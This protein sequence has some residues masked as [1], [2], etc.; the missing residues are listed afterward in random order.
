MH[1]VAAEADTLV[2]L[3]VHAALASSLATGPHARGP[4]RPEQLVSVRQRQ[5][6]RLAAH[7]FRAIDTALLV[8]TALLALGRTHAGPLLD[9][10]LGDVLAVAAGTAAL[11]WLLRTM[12]L[13]RFGR[14]D[15]PVG[16]VGRIAAATGLAGALTAL[17]SWLVPAPETTTTTAVTAVAGCGLV[18]TGAHLMWFGLVARWKSRGLLTANVV[19]VGATRHADELVASALE[20]RD[21]HVLGIFDDRAERSPRSIR[22]VPVLGTTETLLHHR[23]LPFVDLI[24][25]AIDPSAAARVRQV[26]DRLSVLPN[27]VTLLVDGPGTDRRTA[28]ID[29]LTDTALAPLA[30]PANPSRKAYAKRVQDVAIAV[31]LLALTAPVM[32]LIALAI[33]L[34]SRGPVFFRQRRHGFN[35]EEIVVWKFRTMRAESADATAARQVTAGDDRVTRVGRIL[36]M[37]GLDELP[38]LF[39]VVTGAMSLVGPRPH[40]IGMRTGDAEAAELVAE[41]AQRHRIKPGMTGWAAINGSRGPVHT[42]DEV[43]ERV[44]LDIAYIERQSFW[45]DVLIMAKTVPTMLGD[46]VAVR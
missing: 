8:A 12:H 27:P 23:V 31:P 7:R 11:W 14:R 10:A 38:Q 39:N 22:G 15:R 5:A 30:A 35:N 29:Q 43:A 19:I 1:Q 18:V 24:L 44:A 2:E 4:L 40:A 45:L 21:I 37:T 33:R 34:D 32:A 26:M 13:Y 3:D 41:Y 6:R 28:A 46:R 9:A 36:R 25:I 16:H 42:A 20:R 17:I